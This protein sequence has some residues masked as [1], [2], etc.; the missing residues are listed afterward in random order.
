MNQS[1][2]LSRRD[3]MAKLDAITKE[4][5]N[6]SLSEIYENLRDDSI[7]DKEKN[8]AP[9]ST[10]QQ[11]NEGT[12]KEPHET[13]TNEE[14]KIEKEEQNSEG[15]LKEPHEEPISEVP[16][17]EK[18]GQGNEGVPKE[19]HEETISEEPKKSKKK[20]NIK[21]Q[22]INTHNMYFEYDQK[23]ERK[24]K[25]TGIVLT[26]TVYDGVTKYAK[27]HGTSFNDITHQLLEAFL[28]SLE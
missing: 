5:D 26:Q 7:S 9:A 24:T 22:S 3:V 13:P 10:E 8:E 21:G 14:P 1:K 12:P 18:E 20:K 15:V 17:I 4:N 19:P 23:R 2:R 25:R 28:K 16:K 11:D 27:E 6:S